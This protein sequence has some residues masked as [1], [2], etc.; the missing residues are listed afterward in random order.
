V[1][2][3]KFEHLNIPATDP[4]GLAKWYAKTFD[5]KAK[6]HLVRGPGILIAFQE[7]EPINRAPDLHIGFRVPS[8]KSLKKWAK[9][10]DAELTVGDEFT[11]FRT[12]DPEGNCLELY[13]ANA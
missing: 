12:P 3:L 5:L 6:K 9:K 1:P 7:G 13:A 4:I 11:A 8:M 10:F 2:K